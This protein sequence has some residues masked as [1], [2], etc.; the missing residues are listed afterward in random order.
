M[1]QCDRLSAVG[2]R[3]PYQPEND[4]QALAWC[5]TRRITVRWS[6]VDAK[7]EVSYY[8]PGGGV[9]IADA[10]TFLVAVCDTIRDAH[11]MTG[12]TYNP[13]EAE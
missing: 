7:V 10:D 2:V 5:R 3:G 6:A 9:A 13:Q 4:T 11:A 8:L 12:K 1:S